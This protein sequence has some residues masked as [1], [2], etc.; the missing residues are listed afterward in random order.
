MFEGSES[1]CLLSLWTNYFCFGS[2][3]LLMKGYPF[4]KILMCN[5]GKL[6]D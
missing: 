1:G 2:Y 6:L 5:F 3:L 4:S